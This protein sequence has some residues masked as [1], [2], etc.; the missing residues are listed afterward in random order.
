MLGYVVCIIREAHTSRFPGF[1]HV[2]KLRLMTGGI[3]QYLLD[4]SLLQAIHIN[5]DTIW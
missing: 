1:E 3:I 5:M 4:L 2:S